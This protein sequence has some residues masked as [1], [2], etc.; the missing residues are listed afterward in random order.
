MR[1]TTRYDENDF[2]KALMGTLHETGH[3]LGLPHTAA[4]D[5][6]MYSF[7]Y[8]GDIPE[9]FARYRRKLRTRDDIGRNSGLSEADRKRVQM[10]FRN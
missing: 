9:Y 10:E 6:I 4:F 1:L 2:A 8:G 5:D 3:A 7:Q